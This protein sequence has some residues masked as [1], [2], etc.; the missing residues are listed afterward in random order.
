MVVESEGT[1]ARLQSTKKQLALYRYENQLFNILL[2]QSGRFDLNMLPE[3]PLLIRTED[4]AHGQFSSP[5]KKHR[6]ELVCCVL[7]LVHN[8]ELL[9]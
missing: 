9:P 8:N 4:A 2:D 3:P 7:V 5:Y 6:L 1:K